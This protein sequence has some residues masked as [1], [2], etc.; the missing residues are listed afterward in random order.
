MIRAWLVIDDRGR[1]AVF[2]DQAKAEQYAAE[3]HGELFPLALVV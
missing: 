3:H 2:L 1:E